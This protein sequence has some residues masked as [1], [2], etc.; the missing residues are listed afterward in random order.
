MSSTSSSRCYHLYLFKCN[1]LL[2]PPMHP[3]QSLNKD[4][5]NTVLGSVSQRQKTE[6]YICWQYLHS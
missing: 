1:L 4:I 2:L 6:L 5:K 3:T